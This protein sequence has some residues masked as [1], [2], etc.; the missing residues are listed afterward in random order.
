[1]IIIVLGGTNNINCELSEF[2]KNRCDKC[3][4]LIDN[5]K[6][7]D[8]HFSGGLN[9]KFNRSNISHSEICKRYFLNKI[10]NKNYG[11]IYL[12]EINNNTVD[13]AINFGIYFCNSQDEIKIITNEWHVNRVNY[14]FSKTFKFYN[15]KKFKIISVISK[16][17][18]KNL[19][20]EECKKLSQLIKNPYGTW[21]DW[22]EKS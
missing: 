1:M 4:D 11:N 16:E 7:Y 18:D 2:T 17:I 19:E 6:D 13:E 5:E 15:I 10:D 9:K 20:S 12:H 22:L 21:K 3:I 8:I 14:L